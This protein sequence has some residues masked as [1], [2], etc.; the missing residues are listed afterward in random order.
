MGKLQSLKNPRWSVA[1]FAPPGPLT[2]ARDK[3][4]DFKYVK[5]KYIFKYRDKFI[6]LSPEIRL[7]KV[8]DQKC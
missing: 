7:K 2:W 4:T 1:I 5:Y 6:I 8:G 3:V